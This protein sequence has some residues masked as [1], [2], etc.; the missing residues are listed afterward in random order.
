MKTGKITR[1]E[2]FRVGLMRHWRVKN[3]T[4]ITRMQSGFAVMCDTQLL[5]GYV[6]QLA[7][8]LVEHLN[9][10]GLEQQT[11]YLRDMALIGRVVEEVTRCKRV[12][13]GILAA[14][15]QF[16]TAT[17]SLGMNGKAKTSNAMLEMPTRTALIPN[18]FS[19]R[20]NTEIC[21]SG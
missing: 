12:M 14:S 4:S 19:H 21:N 16:C 8:P 20:K 5:P 15:T 13:Y 7:N 3:P 11:T 2:G 10:L 1:L 17:F 18:I 6:I 9:S